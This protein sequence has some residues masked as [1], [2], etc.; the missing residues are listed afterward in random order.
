MQVFKFGGAS[1]KSAEAIKRVALLLK[2][3]APAQVAVVVSAMGKM[4]NALERVLQAWH[5][6]QPE[7]ENHLETCKQFHHEIMCGLFPDV[8]HPSYARVAGLFEQLEKYLLAKPS[9]N[10]DYDYD[11]VV[12]YGELVSTVIV[13]EYLRSQGF[14]CRWF[15]VRKL[16][17][18]DDTWREGT[19]D[20]NA[21][22]QA[23][24]QAA[25]TAFAGDGTPKILLTQGFLGG[26]KKG[27]TT[28]LGRE[29]SD[30]SAAVFSNALNAEEMTAWKDVPGVLSA[31]PKICADAVL[32]PHISYDEAAKLTNY[33][34]TIL[35]PKTIKPL[36]DK[37]IPLRVRSF[38]QPETTG[39]LISG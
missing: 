18:T 7:W 35:H 4:T 27:Q 2:Q 10:Y 17:I 25:H 9:G 37:R 23:I 33:G 15:D 14:A 1:V 20:W 38:L 13:D 24:R 34:A 32:L 12:S 30:Y 21:T 29:G 26:T 28:T 8:A 31:D 5:T 6:G 16:I 36:Q 11:Q 3:Y 22:E 19:I 39:T